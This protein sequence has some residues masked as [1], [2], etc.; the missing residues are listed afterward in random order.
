MSDEQLSRTVDIEGPPAYDDWREQLADGTL[1]GTECA[2]C[3]Q[4]T[5]TPKRRCS[6]CGSEQL[7]GTVL[8]TTGTVY[9]ETTIEVTPAGFDDSYQI[10][11]VDLDGTHLTSRIEGSVAIGERVQFADIITTDDRP[12]PVFEPVK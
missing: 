8:P 2:S 10:A 11:I 6:R 7:D 12:A 9:S 5:A 1:L 4:T 3:G